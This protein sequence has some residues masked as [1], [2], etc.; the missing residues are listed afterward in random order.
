MLIAGIPT[1]FNIPWGN[2]A[3]GGF[4]RTIPEASQIG[5]QAG[6]AS[7]T[8]GFPPVTFLPIGAG[9][10]PP[11]GADFNGI[12]NQVTSWQRWNQ[13]GGPIAFDAIFSA[14]MG[15]YPLGALLPSALTFGDYWLSTSDGN[16]TNPDVGGAG[17]QSVSLNGGTLTTGAWTWRPTQET[18]PGWAKANTTTIGNAASNGTQ[19]ANADTL[20]LFSWL[21]TNFSNTQCPVFTSAGVPSTRGANAAA[22]FAANKT[23]ATLDMRGYGIG[24]MDTMG[25]PP[26]TRLAGVPVTFGSAT[27]ASSIL[28][29]NLHALLVAELATHAHSVSDAGHGHAVFDPQH[30]HGFTYNNI[31]GFLGGGGFLLAGG[32]SAG[33]NNVNFSLNAASTGVSIVVNTTGISIGNNGSGTAHNT[34]DQKILGTHYLKY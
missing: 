17:W 29:E 26:T 11:W 27:Q 33:V 13:A 3:G 12:L 16:T 7:L 20:N 28:G 21:W 2:S 19:R 24:G 32:G 34:Y 18:V 9:G 5:I 31:L 14:A 4:I 10:T 23:I 15:G 6:A 8:D 22:D 1:K 25:G 30:T